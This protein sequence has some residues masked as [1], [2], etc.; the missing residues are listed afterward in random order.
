MTRR[1]E[2]YRNSYLH[3]IDP[4]RYTDMHTD[5]RHTNTP[6]LRTHVHRGITITKCMYMS[7]T[8]HNGHC[9]SAKIKEE[10]VECIDK[11]T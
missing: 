9:V 3:F 10:A 6:H 5:R 2:A 8:V 7:R 11:T 1:L 4:D